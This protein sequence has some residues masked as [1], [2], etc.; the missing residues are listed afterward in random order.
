MGNQVSTRKRGKEKSS[1]SL[2]LLA[3]S[4]N[5]ISTTS[6]CQPKL[7][8]EY[9]FLHNAEEFDRL[10]GQ[11]YLLKHLFQGNF[12][13][14][15]SNSLSNPD[16]KALDIG[17]GSYGIWMRDMAIDFPE[18]E[19]YGFD[20]AKPA[21][22]SETEKMHL[23]ENFHIEQADLFNG[24]NYKTNT[25]DF[26]HQ[27]M[28]YNVYPQDKIHWMFEE[29]LRVTKQN[30]WIE[31]VE[32]DLVPKRAG[33]LFSKLT[34]ALHEFLHNRL[35]SFLQGK[36]LVDYMNK[37]GLVDIVSDYGSLPCCWGGYIGKLFYEDILV[38]MRHYGPF[39]HEYLNDGT[40]FNT[41]SFDAII[42]AAFDEC[43]E[44]QTFFNIRWACGKKV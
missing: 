16:S 17:C 15:L 31:M 35:G 11:H 6:S 12:L 32:P 1:K 40:E 29:L 5:E 23:P 26:V 28:M 19:F 2:L 41:E 24:F 33:P 39:I 14:P 8:K 36:D 37:S 18:C 34:K 27:R 22:L 4:H 44:Y 38:A 21:E 42:D 30:G 43:A 3:E 20:L 7:P 25:F 10:N 9:V 13:A